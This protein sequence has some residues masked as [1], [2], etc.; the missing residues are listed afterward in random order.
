MSGESFAYFAL[1]GWMSGWMGAS[2]ASVLPHGTLMDAVRRVAQNPLAASFLHAATGHGAFAVSMTGD[3][4]AAWPV[5]GTS[6]WIRI[7]LLMLGGVLWSTGDR[8]K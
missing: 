2:A 1:I 6:L 5:D 4:S 3:V 7:S 8:R